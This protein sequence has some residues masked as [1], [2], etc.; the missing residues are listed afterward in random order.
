ML[1]EPGLFVDIGAHI[2]LFSCAVAATPGSRVIAVEADCGNCAA[3]RANVALNGRRNVTIVNAAAGRDFAIVPIVRRASGNSG[4]VA[5]EAHAAG[6]IDWVPTM[7]LD[8]M[9]SR[10]VDPPVR[11]VL[12]KIDTEG[13]EPQVLAGLDFSGP[14]RPRNI[15]MEC[16]PAFA[17]KSWGG[18][19]E[20]HTFLSAKGYEVL[21]V[22]GRPLAS[23][24]T[25]QEANIWAC[26]R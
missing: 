22:F 2:G 20:M 7:P 8:R 25:P 21:D 15:I 1:D 3:L 17:E 23:S 19:A 9:L 5:V 16:E 10:L 11:P 14:F 24:A 4:T 13:L 12:I 6:T 26:E 18:L